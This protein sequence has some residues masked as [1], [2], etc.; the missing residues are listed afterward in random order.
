MSYF[1][2]IGWRTAKDCGK[3]QPHSVLKLKPFW[4]SLVAGLL[5]FFFF[6]KSC[7]GVVPVET[8]GSL[9]HHSLR[10]DSFQHNPTCFVWAVRLHPEFPKAAF[11]PRVSSVVCKA[12]C[13]LVATIIHTAKIRTTR[14]KI[15]NLIQKAEISTDPFLQ[16]YA[17]DV[18]FK[19]LA[20]QM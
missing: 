8:E 7:S 2:I 4:S 11:L 16:F 10:N 19:S 20:I 9:S 17:I 18:F 15:Q 3:A 5:L 6:L 1:L 12:L 13:P 14:L